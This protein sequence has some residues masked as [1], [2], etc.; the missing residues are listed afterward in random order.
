LPKHAGD[1]NRTSPFAFTG[2][3]FEFRALGSSQS[4]S[5]PATVLNTIVAES[6]DELCSEL[7]SR[8]EKGKDLESALRDVLVAEIPKFKRILFGGDNYTPEWH[9]EAE[10]RGLLNLRTTLDALKKLSDPKNA[11][12]FEKYGVLTK[13]E[14]ESREEIVVDQYFKTVNIEGE[15]TADMA[16]TM[17]LPAA[18]HYLNELLTTAERSSGVGVQPEGVLRT[19]KEVNALINELTAV[20]AELV[21][22]NEE[23]G[24]DDV[25]SKAHHMHEHIIPAMAKVR[26]VADKLERVVPDYLWPLPRYRDMLFVK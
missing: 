6:I 22:Q 20:L 1:R 26:R 19:A 13:R 9:Q 12:L 3:K 10:K 21:K 2:N 16:S 24:G 7:E 17:I 15:T 8:I 23:L 14:F 18:V 11:R 4:I 5:W 25:H